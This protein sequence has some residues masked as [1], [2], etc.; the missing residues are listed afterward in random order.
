MR[1]KVSDREEKSFAAESN[2]IYTMSCRDKASA[3]SEGADRHKCL[4]LHEIQTKKWR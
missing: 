4:S 2:S 1:K 3:L